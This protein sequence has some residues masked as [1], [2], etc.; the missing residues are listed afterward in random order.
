MIATQNWTKK[1]KIRFNLISLILIIGCSIKNNKPNG[2]LIENFGATS[3]NNDSACFYYYGSKSST[4]KFCYFD[5][6]YN[7]FNKISEDCKN[8]DYQKLDS[9]LIFNYPNGIKI[10]STKMF[11]EMI[12]KILKNDKKI[13][14]NEMAK[15]LISQLSISNIAEIRSSVILDHTN[16]NIIDSILRSHSYYKY[17]LEMPYQNLFTAQVGFIN[18]LKH[19]ILDSNTFFFAIFSKRDIKIFKSNYWIRNNQLWF[20]LYFLRPT[21]FIYNRKFRLG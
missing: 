16:I 15:W 8:C 1:L 20:E 9:L 13:L 2:L 21:I 12:N 4:L 10:K 6:N 7:F 18:N 3:E 19:E 14:N 11:S 17:N 5:S